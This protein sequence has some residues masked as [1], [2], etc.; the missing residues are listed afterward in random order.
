MDRP[1]RF[2]SSATPT[3]WLPRLEAA[4]GGEVKHGRI[5]GLGFAAGMVERFESVKVQDVAEGSA[6]AQAG[7]KPGDVILR[8]D[9]APVA[10]A[11]RLATIL[12]IYPEGQ[13]VEVTVQR[14][15]AE[16]VLRT[17]L[18]AP[19][20]CQVGMRLDRPGGDAF[21][22]RVAEVEAGTPAA[23]G[24]LQVGDEIVAIN[25]LPLRL[26]SQQEFRALERSLREQFNEGAIFT[27]KVRRGRGENK[28]PD[29]FDVRVVG[30]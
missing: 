5:P 10:N 15:G 25:G 3:L 22:P 11:V 8:L 7:F 17:T 2:S 23:T 16:L 13:D 14:G 28:E 6:A 18:V 24:G 4:G 1:S 29:E 27:F 19:K 30:R 9:D 26:R 21:V 20:R 12:G